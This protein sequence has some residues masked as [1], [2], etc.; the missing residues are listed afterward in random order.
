[1]LFSV[2]F[3]VGRG[4]AL[5]W[6]WNGSRRCWRRTRLSSNLCVTCSRSSW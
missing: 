3:F 1:M 6:R 4:D 2:D 5:P